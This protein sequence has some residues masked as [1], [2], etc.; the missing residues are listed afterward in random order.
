MELKI[1]PGYENHLMGYLPGSSDELNKRRQA[2]GQAMMSYELPEGMKMEDRVIPGGDGQDMNIRIYTPAN[3]PEGAPMVLDIH[4]GAFVAGNLDIDNARCIAIAARIPAIV[5]GVEYRLSVNGVHF[6]APLMD[7][8]AAYLW[9][10]DNAA[11]L[12][13]DGSKIGIHGSSSGG[14]LSEGLA[15]YLRD[16]NEQTPALTV[17]NC[18]TY[19]PAIQETTSFQQLIQVKMGPDN[20]ALG[21][22][23]AYLGGYDGTQPSYYAF[24]SLCPDVGGLGAHFIIAGEYDTLRDS[25]IDYAQRLLRAAVPT[26]LFMA[27]RVGHCFSCAPH[28]FTDQTHD[29]IATMFRREFGMLDDLKKEV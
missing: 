4:G 8:R 7:C 26:D 28:P 18:A 10:K 24:P 3:L 25:A 12:G 19:S 6:P 1:F 22:E 16:H 21:A 9:M 2:Q 29:L 15:L 17:L 11:S 5:V 27:G 23:A 13:A 14:N 20:K